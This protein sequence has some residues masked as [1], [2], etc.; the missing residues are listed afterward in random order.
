MK[1]TGEHPGGLVS[2][3][4]VRAHRAG[5]VSRRLAA[6]SVPTL[7]VGGHTPFPRGEPPPRARGPRARPAASRRGRGALACRSAASGRRGADHS[8]KRVRPDHRSRTPLPSVIT[9]HSRFLRK[10]ICCF[11]CR[12]VKGGVQLPGA[13]APGA[14]ALTGEWVV[15]VMEPPSRGGGGHRKH[16]RSAPMQDIPPVHRPD[17]DRPPVP[18]PGPGQGPLGV[19]QITDS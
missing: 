15:T 4:A 16:R 12:F 14:C 7:R 5:R 10:T 18:S 3:V 2:E 11:G 17:H 6:T 8:P 1:S 13:Y 9:T 19:T